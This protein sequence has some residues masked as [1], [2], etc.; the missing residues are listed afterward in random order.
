MK[1]LE[2][3]ITEQIPRLRR[4]A[5]ALT[6]GDSPRA[7]DLVQD[8]LERAWSRLYRWRRGS[9]IRAWMF[10]IMHNLYINQVRRYGNG[11]DFVSLKEHEASNTYAPH[12]ESGLLLQE[13]HT[14]IGELPLE[15]REILL[16]VTLEGMRYE[17]VAKVLDIP[18][19]TVM[20]RLSRARKRLRILLAS[21]SGPRL[22]RIK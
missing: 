19:G 3:D 8:C 10:T 20:S 22:R 16:M 9:D 17:Q 13:L 18:E 5:H 2:Q 4:Y 6:R 11:P 1:S 7:D 14:A 21:G 12:Q 15:Q